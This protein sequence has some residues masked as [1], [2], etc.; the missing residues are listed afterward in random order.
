VSVHTTLSQMWLKNAQNAV[1]ADP[2]FRKRGSID[3][4]MA[5][6]SDQATYLITFGG[7]SCHEVRSIT[8]AGLRDADF[9][10]DMSADQWDRFLQNRR[11]GTGRTLVEIDNTDDVVKAINPRKKLD[12]LRYHTSLQAFFDAGSRADSPQAA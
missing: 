5:L 8:D 10:V 3:V 6:K 1:N 2:S 9:V 11:S 4:K 12:F 7:F